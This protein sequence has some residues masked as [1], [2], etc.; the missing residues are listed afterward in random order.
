M[1]KQKYKLTWSDKLVKIIAII[2]VIIGIF[3]YILQI[4]LLIN[5]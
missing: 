2:I 3:T 5:K 4:L 1:E